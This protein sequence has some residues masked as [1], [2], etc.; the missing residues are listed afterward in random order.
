M[1][2]EYFLDLLDLIMGYLWDIFSFGDGCLRGWLIQGCAVGAADSSC[3]VM[4]IWGEPYQ[5]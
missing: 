3:Y 4:Y 5:P 1:D 2:L